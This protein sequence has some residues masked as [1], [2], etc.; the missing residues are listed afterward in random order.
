MDI[1]FSK[2]NIYFPEAGNMVQSPIRILP[3][4]PSKLKNSK[5]N[6]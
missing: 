6:N 1:R 3:K 5:E 4:L 2:S